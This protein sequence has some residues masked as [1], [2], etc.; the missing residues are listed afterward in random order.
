[1]AKEIPVE[2]P[3]LTDEEQKIVDLLTDRDMETIDYE[4]LANSKTRR[5]KPPW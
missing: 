4:L 1:M 2:M 3:P 5:Q